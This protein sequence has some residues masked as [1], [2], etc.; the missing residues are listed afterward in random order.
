MI[1]TNSTQF[2]N[3]TTIV[4]DLD[5]REPFDY[6]SCHEKKQKTDE[7]GKSVDLEKPGNND[8]NNIADYYECDQ[9]I[10]CDNMSDEGFQC[11][12]SYIAVFIAFGIITGLLILTLPVFAIF[13]IIFGFIV[14][15]RRIRKLS[16][17]FLLFLL[18]AA[19]VG[20]CSTYAWYGKPNLVACNFQP[21]L[22]GLSVNLMISF[23]FSF[24]LFI[25]SNF[26][27]FILLFNLF[28]FLFICYLFNLF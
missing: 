4:P 17:T 3:G 27:Y 10:D 12:P 18:V 15:R 1:F 7:T 20:Y 11:V 26:I 25:Y 19:F 2:Y 23:F 14:K 28:L 13:A 21:W 5:V 9:Y 24:I 6:W 22:L 16:P 8:P